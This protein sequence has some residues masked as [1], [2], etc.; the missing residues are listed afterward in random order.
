M[1]LLPSIL[2]FADDTV[3]LDEVPRHELQQMLDICGQAATQ[4]GQ[5]FNEK[6]SANVIFAGDIEQQMGQ[7]TIQGKEIQFRSWYKYLAVEI[8]DEGD[9]Y[10]R[11]VGIRKTRATHGEQMVRMKALW[12]CNRFLVS[13][14]LWKTLFVPTVTYANAVVTMGAQVVNSFDTTQRA[15]A[16][17]AM[18]CRFTCASQFLEG[19][20]GVSSFWAREAQAKSSY[21][22]RLRMMIR[23]GVDNWAARMLVLN[24]L[25]KIK[26]EWDRLPYFLSENI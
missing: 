24:N 2:R 16:R 7:M 14:E 15:V 11:E 20:F 17:Q 9:I 4:L 23:D 21:E 5:Y 26:S 18:Q 25:E 13:R 3:L 22:A 19:E 1:E 8:G 6:K 10:N 12:I